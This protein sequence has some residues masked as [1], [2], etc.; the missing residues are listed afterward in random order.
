[1]HRSTHSRLSMLPKPTYVDLKL[2]WAE[3]SIQAQ[4][5]YYYPTAHSF[6]LL[7]AVCIAYDEEMQHSQFVQ[8]GIGFLCAVYEQR[9]PSLH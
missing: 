2:N 1:M 8:S 9:E 5:I 3:Y 4:H 7:C 6:H